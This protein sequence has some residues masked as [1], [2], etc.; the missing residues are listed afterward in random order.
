[1]QATAYYAHSSWHIRIAHLDQ[2]IFIVSQHSLHVAVM[3]VQPGLHLLCCVVTPL[4][5]PILY[6]LWGRLV[7][8][9]VY[10]T[11]LRI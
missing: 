6:V 10:F 9:M 11:C 2:D 8:Q 3:V 7:L 4:C 1:M 5:Q